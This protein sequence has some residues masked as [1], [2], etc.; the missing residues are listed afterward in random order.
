MII[1]SLVHTRLC[2]YSLSPP[3]PSAPIGPLPLI[4]VLPWINSWRENMYKSTD[5]FKHTLGGDYALQKFFDV[6]IELAVL[7]QELTFYLTSFQ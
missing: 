1:I 2:D 6:K 5:N 3:S 4:V 7:A